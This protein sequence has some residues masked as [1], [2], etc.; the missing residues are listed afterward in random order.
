MTPL[1]AYE[2]VFTFR[3]R[4][5]VERDGY[6]GT[7][8]MATKRETAERI[9]PFSTI[10]VA[11]DADWGQRANDLGIQIAFQ[12]DLLVFHPARSSFHDLYGKWERHS[13][14]EYLHRRR[15]SAFWAGLLV[16]RAIL[17]LAATVPHISKIL[18]CDQ[19]QGWRANWLA[20]LGLL[21]V[22]W[23]RARTL[24]ALAVSPRF[25]NQEITWNR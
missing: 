4:E 8:N 5:M 21:R 6:A 10:D 18:Q 24:V 13:R 23:F 15:Q 7:G 9:G 25:R 20:F 14:H 1:I 12:P 3:M 16:F 19:L 2:I 22:R 11:E 17:I